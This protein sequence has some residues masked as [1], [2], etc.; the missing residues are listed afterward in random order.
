MLTTWASEQWWTQLQNIDGA[1]KRDVHL[2][3]AIKHNTYRI[4]SSITYN[5]LNHCLRRAY[6][7]KKRTSIECLHLLIPNFDGPQLL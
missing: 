4:Y 5:C 1:E 7:V 3:R 6:V 2:I